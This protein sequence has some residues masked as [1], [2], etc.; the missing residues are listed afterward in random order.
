MNII[1]RL[2][3]KSNHELIEAIDSE[4][5]RKLK[6]A[7]ASGE[8]SINIWDSRKIA[9]I[10][11]I[12]YGNK[13]LDSITFRQL[14]LNELSENRLF[15]LA[16]KHT[17]KAFTDT[18]TN[19]RNLANLKWNKNSPL[20]KIFSD[21]LNFTK[22]YLPKQVYKRSATDIITPHKHLPPLFDYQSDLISK[23]IESI[24]SGKKGFLIQLPTGAGKTRV[25]MEAL[26]AIKNM[27]QNPISMGSI[28]WLA[29]TGELIEQAIETF[30]NTWA[31]CSEDPIKINRLYST[32]NPKEDDLSDALI[33]GSLQK[34][35]RMASVNKSQLRSIAQLISI[36]VIDEAHKV[37]AP[38]YRKAIDTI[39][40]SNKI[41]CIGVTATPGR[42]SD[43]IKQNKDF[44]SFFEKTLLTPDLGDE[45]IRTLQKL[46]ILAKLKRTIV[47]TNYELPIVVDADDESD[48]SDKIL[49]NIALSSDR[50]RV[51]IQTI[52]EQVQKGN[53]TIVFSCS[54]EHSALLCAGLAL[55]GIRASLVDHTLSKGSRRKI[56]EEFTDGGIDVLI[57]Y[58]ILSTGF[59]APR[60]KTVVIARP[61]KSVILYSQMIGRGLRGLKVGG[62]MDCNLIDLIDNYKKHGDVEQIYGCFSEYWS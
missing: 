26:I 29:H 51:I 19:A 28:L 49:R 38:T 35:G 10:V 15:Q 53:P 9:N 11:D 58:G 7:Q 40:K 33:F 21:E 47:H 23:I 34:F 17:T 37:L 54:I 32:Y 55:N 24:S 6:K 5:K 62:N 43:D 4:W 57:N 1:E 3:L 61:T 41:I 16:K 13:I 22:D 14:F 50:N 45:P 12:I 48:Y 42:H 59:D 2:A 30:S 25:M 31:E 36:V 60:I 18:K 8:E 44:T 27:D 52:C 56:I 46:G 39:R 20:I